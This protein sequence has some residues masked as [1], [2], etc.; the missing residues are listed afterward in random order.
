MENFSQASEEVQVGLTDDDYDMYYEMWQK[1]DPNGTEFISYKMLSDFV[2]DL[3]PPLGI[4]KPNKLKLISLNITI[5]Q[6]NKLHCSDILDALTK[7]FLGS[8]D[9]VEQVV[10]VEILKKGMPNF[11][12]PITTTLKLQ[13]ENYAATV[14]TRAIKNYLKVKKEKNVKTQMAEI[15]SFDTISPFTT[16]PLS[17]DYEPLD[18][19]TNSDRQSQIWVDF[20]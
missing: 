5:C 8:T 18:S 17:P 12:E 20:I 10:P 15:A 1:Y 7:N 2:D 11:Y 19:F 13:R 3:D 16:P 14:L 4:P 9:D 6:D